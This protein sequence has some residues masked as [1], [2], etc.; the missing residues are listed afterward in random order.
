MV[1]AR[2][3]TRRR[4]LGGAGGGGRG[5]RGGRADDRGRRRADGG[6]LGPRERGAEGLGQRVGGEVEVHAPAFAA[7]GVGAHAYQE[8]FGMLQSNSVTLAGQEAGAADIEVLP[9]EEINIL[10]AGI[11]NCEAEL[12]GRSEER[13]VG[14]ECRSRWAPYH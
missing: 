9:D 12:F 13:R 5:G 4:R 10:V 7:V 3:V 14:K 2:G 8:Y 6:G 11:D 1:G